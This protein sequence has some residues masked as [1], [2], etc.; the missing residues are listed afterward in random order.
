MVSGIRQVTQ[1]LLQ[2]LPASGAKFRW[3]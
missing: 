2:M 3:Q 1:Y